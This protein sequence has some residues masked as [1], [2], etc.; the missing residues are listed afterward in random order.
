MAKPLKPKLQ[1]TKTRKTPKA[2]SI[3]AQL[4]EKLSTT[5]FKDEKQNSVLRISGMVQ[6]LEFC[7]ISKNTEKFP[8]NMA[9]KQ[10]CISGV[11]HCCKSY[12]CT[13][14]VR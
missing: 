12:Y 2:F 5:P 1:A 7:S 6:A 9:M 13:Q 10:A 11:P 4:T 14:S 3:Q 8:D